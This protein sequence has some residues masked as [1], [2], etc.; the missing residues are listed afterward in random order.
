MKMTGKGKE[1]IA[2][3]VARALS[4]ANCWQRRSDQ[5]GQTSAKLGRQVA[6]RSKGS[7]P[8]SK[9]SGHKASSH[10]LRC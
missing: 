3:G 8:A 7:Q 10:V 4:L 9:K 2:E 1:L 5:V 6:Q